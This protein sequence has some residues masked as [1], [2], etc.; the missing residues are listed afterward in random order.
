MLL[1]GT[2]VLDHKNLEAETFIAFMVLFAQLIPPAK[3]FSSAAYN[4]RKG[5]ASAQRIFEVMDADV[6]IAEKG[7]AVAIKEFK[8]EIEFKLNNSKE[9][10]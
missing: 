5:L 8:T 9:P 7:N 3:N 4:I 10:A 2:L 6:S 1:E